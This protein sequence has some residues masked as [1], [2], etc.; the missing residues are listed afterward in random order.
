MIRTVTSGMGSHSVHFSHY[1]LLN[2]KLTESVIMKIRG[3]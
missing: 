1:S 3:F 2:S